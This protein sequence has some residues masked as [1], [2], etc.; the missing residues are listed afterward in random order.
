MAV[1]ASFLSQLEVYD[2]EVGI[3]AKTNTQ[4]HRCLLFPISNFL[5]SGLIMKISTLLDNP[6]LSQLADEETPTADSDHLHATGLV[7]E[8]GEP[9]ELE[10]YN[11]ISSKIVILIWSC[12]SHSWLSKQP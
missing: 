11:D 10:D 5:S 1:C 3:V 7:Q 8:G 6:S 12:S 4:T 9:D 2:G